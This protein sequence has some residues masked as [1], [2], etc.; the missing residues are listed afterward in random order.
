MSFSAYGTFSDVFT[1][2][3]ASCFYRLFRA[4]FPRM[5]QSGYAFFLTYRAVRRGRASRFYPFVSERA[6]RNSRLFRSARLTTIYGLS[7]FGTSCLRF[8]F[9][10]ERMSEGFAVLESLGFALRS[11]SASLVVH[12]F[13]RTGRRAL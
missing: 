8:R 6:S 5:S 12:R 11:A 2:R 7:R 13:R 4:I 10:L 1:F 9:F 3:I